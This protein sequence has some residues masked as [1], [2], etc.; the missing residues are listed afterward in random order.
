MGNSIHINWQEVEAVFEMPFEGRN[1]H[2]DLHT[3]QVRYLYVDTAMYDEHGEDDDFSITEE[4][5]DAEP[6]RYLYIEPPESHEKYGWM[7]YFA[8][9]L[10][11]E[12]IRRKL[13]RALDKRH[14]FRRFRDAL[15]EFPEVRQQWF[16]YEAK[17][18][19][20]FMREWVYTIPATILNPPDWITGE[21]SALSDE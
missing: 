15:F 7:E 14:P 13:F 12:D 9:Q 19:K 5:I 18:L 8:D 1:A 20:V 4:E 3:G 16:D 2:L 21:V 6:G 10:P 17:R 11:Q